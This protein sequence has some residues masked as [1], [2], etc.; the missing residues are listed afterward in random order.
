MD[1][2]E[3]WDVGFSVVRVRFR[4][5]GGAP[6]VVDRRGIAVEEGSRKLILGMERQVLLVR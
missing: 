3:S 1:G 6:S 4:L 2:V 5:R